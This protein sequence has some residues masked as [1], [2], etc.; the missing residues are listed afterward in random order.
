M[1]FRIVELEYDRKMNRFWSN[2]S[3]PK[4]RMKP[5]FHL[6]PLSHV[7]RHTGEGWGG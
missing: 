3:Q 2:L 6:V 1:L 5:N 7:T 4:L